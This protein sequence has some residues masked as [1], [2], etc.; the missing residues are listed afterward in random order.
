MT[1]RMTNDLKSRLLEGGDEKS[2]DHIQKSTR[3]WFHFPVPANMRATVYL[4]REPL[5]PAA[6]QIIPNEL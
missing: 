2:G 4:S 3:L 5:L 1:S 6:S